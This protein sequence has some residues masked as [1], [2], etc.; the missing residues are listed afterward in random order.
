MRS[1]DVLRLFK[2]CG[3]LLEGHFVLSSG[4]H[5]PQYMQCALLLQH[6]AVASKLCL[7]LAERFIN[8]DITCVVA[9]AM[10]GIVVGYETARHLRV[11]SIFGE[12]QDGKFTLRRGF[13]LGPADRCLLVEDVVTTGGSVEE[14]AE[15]VKNAGAAVVGY[16]AIVDR[17][18]G[19]AVFD[20]KFHALLSMEI[21]T[22]EADHCPM[23]KEEIPIT[24]PG[25]RGLK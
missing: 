6:P 18:N 21:K 2:E 11:R 5:S 10:G 24:K 17:S 4:L 9:P 15:V 7:A 14:L 12:R 13:T 23:C 8:D 22:F 20:M 1:D 19:W 16:G 25:S 3:A